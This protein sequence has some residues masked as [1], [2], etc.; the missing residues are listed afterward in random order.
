MYIY[1]ALVQDGGYVS[2]V[3]ELLVFLGQKV[4]KDSCE[5]IEEY[6]Y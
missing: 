1:D 6:D 4:W 5:T 3:A 2:R